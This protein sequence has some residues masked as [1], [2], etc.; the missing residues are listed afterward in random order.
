MIGFFLSQN[1]LKATYFHEHKID[2]SV[3]MNKESSTAYENFLKFI[4][5]EEGVVYADQHKVIIKN[6]YKDFLVGLK[7]QK[8][9]IFVA[10]G[11]SPGAGKTTYRKSLDLTQQHIHN[12]DEVMSRLP[13]YK[14]DLL[15]IGAKAAF[16]KW[17]VFSR[18]M[19][20]LLLRFAMKSA[21]NVIYDRPCGREENVED[22]LFAKKHGYYVRLVGFYI[23]LEIARQRVLIREFQ[24]GRGVPDNI[25]VDD[26]ARFSAIWKYLLPLVDEASLYSSSQRILTLIF[27]SKQ[28]V[29]DEKL[30]QEFLQG[31][32]LFVDHF[33]KILKS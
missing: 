8:K 4:A 6:L 25:L 32:E 9:P 28:G 12:V 2:S 33:A 5:E 10:I 20:Q 31:G 14:E 30:Y 13:E 15:V 17:V 19:S 24:E 26:H 3:S 21:F 29:V 7:S 1:L 16:A 11:G 22:F 18:R 27:S 23:P